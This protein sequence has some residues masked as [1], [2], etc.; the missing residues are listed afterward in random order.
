MEKYARKGSLDE[1]DLAACT[2]KY[3]VSDLARPDIVLEPVNSRVLSIDGLFI[4][5][6]CILGF[7]H[8]IVE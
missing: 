3:N 6:K 5:R 7:T 1:D 4:I 8:I 2:L